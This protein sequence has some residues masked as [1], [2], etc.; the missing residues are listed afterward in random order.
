MFIM[1]KLKHRHG[2][3]DIAKAGHVQPDPSSYHCL[4]SF[5]QSLKKNGPG[6]R[7]PPPPTRLGLLM[8]KYE[9]VIGKGPRKG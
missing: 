7:L 6:S 4:L 5:C 2:S 9:V 1:Q 3:P 8:N